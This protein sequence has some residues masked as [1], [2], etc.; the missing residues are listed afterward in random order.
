[1]RSTFADF[2]HL[3][4][5]APDALEEAV[6]LGQAVEGV[7]ALTHRSDETAEGV[8]LVLAL[9]GTAVLVDLGD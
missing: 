3:S 1:M 6:S 4:L 9:D 8:D 5:G 2:E 7:V